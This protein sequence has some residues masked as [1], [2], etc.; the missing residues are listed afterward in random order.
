MAQA[1]FRTLKKF[2]KVDSRIANYLAEAD[3]EL[4]LG[5]AR[6]ARKELV[7]ALAPVVVLAH[8]L[9]ESEGGADDLRLGRVSRDHLVRSWY[10]LRQ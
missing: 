10:V 3:D 4:E 2:R 9:I 7:R 8:E 5:V 6:V 1:N